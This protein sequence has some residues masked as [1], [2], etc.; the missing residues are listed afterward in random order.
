MDRSFPSLIFS[1]DSKTVDK[2]FV[3]SELQKSYWANTR[4]DDII[5][6]SIESSLSFSVFMDKKQIAFARVITDCATFA[7]LCDVVVTEKYRGLGIG[8][9]LIDYVL[10]NEKLKDVVWVLR[11]K[12]A[13]SLYEEFG[14]EKTWRPE[15]YMEKNR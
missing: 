10:K 9:K 1:S 7:Y 13:H 2:D 14:F 15:R 3:I 5:L 6:R 11:T 8:K 4:S 12:D